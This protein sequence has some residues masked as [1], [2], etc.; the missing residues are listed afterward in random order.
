LSY[1]R[2]GPVNTGWA[3]AVQAY[4]VAL[5]LTDTTGWHMRPLMR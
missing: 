3:V 5:T 4:F 1:T 2:N